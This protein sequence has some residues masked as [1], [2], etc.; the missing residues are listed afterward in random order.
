MVENRN[1]LV[2]KVFKDH[3]QKVKV[4]IV[5]LVVLGVTKDSATNMKEEHA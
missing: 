5:L 1:H 3:G 2:Q 4:Q